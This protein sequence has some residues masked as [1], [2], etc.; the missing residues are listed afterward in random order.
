MITVEEAQRILQVTSALFSSPSRETVS[1][2]S[3]HNRILAQNIYSS[4]DFPAF[5]NSA[6][7]GFA[8][9]FH[10]IVEHHKTHTPIPISGEIVAGDTPISL[11]R[12]QALKIFTGAPIPYGANCV[13]PIEQ[14][15]VTE[16]YLT[17]TEELSRIKEGQHIRPKGLNFTRN[18]CV[19][20]SGTILNSMNMSVLASIGISSVEVFRKITVAIGITGNELITDSNEI[21]ALGKIYDSNSILLY[22]LCKEQGC[23]IVMAENIPDTLAHTRTFL[24][25]AVKNAD[26]VLTTGGISM[27]DKDFLKVLLND[28]R[29]TN[30]C[31][32]HFQTVAIKPGKPFTF[33]HLQKEKNNTQRN[34]PVFC[35]PGNPLS[36]FIIYLYFVLPFIQK[37][38][39]ND[40]SFSAMERVAA[41]H[42]FSAYPRARFL[43]GI[44]DY[45]KKTIHILENQSSASIKNLCTVNGALI[46]P[47]DKAIEKDDFLDFFHFPLR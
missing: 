40:K 14:C 19:L 42:S 3:A 6:M 47:A 38:A 16:N 9:H 32:V 29:K 5:D 31:T 41:P 11:P 15:I 22:Q 7:D 17:I 30:T 36:V 46:V 43:F 21:L 10:D 4:Y 1:L 24:C 26:V 20:K 27:G 45:A 12:S 25:N 28:L 39:G 44:K 13:I 37:L 35:M 18:E 33:A 2:A 34:I 8:F 23:E